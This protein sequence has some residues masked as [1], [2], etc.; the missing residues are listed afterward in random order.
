MEVDETTK[1]TASSTQAPPYNLSFTPPV[2]A[3]HLHHAGHRAR[4]WGSKNEHPVTVLTTGKLSMWDLESGGA[5]FE[6][7]LRDLLVLGE[8]FHPMPQ[9]PHL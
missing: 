9:F 1:L 4:C 7:Q 3:K 6:P 5:G 8:G 2:F